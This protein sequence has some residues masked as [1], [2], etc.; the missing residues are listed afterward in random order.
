MQK[1][2]LQPPP[3]SS[4]LLL[5]ETFDSDL[6]PVDVLPN[7]YANVKEAWQYLS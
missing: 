3:P 5:S 2:L 4:C 6:P 1:Q 7:I